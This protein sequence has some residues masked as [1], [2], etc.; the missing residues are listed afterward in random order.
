MRSA[1]SEE[2]HGGGKEALMA[3]TVKG[4]PHTVKGGFSLGFRGYLGYILL[5]L[6]ILAPSSRAEDVG[7]VPEYNVYNP[8]LELN[9]GDFMGFCDEEKLQALDLYSIGECAGNFLDPRIPNPLGVLDPIRDDRFRARIDGLMFI[10]L[11]LSKMTFNF[12]PGKLLSFPLNLLL[13]VFASTLELLFNCVKYVIIFAFSFM[14]TYLI[15]FML[16]FQVFLHGIDQGDFFQRINNAHT[17]VLF[18]VFT[19]IVVLVMG[20]GWIT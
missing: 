10:S 2:A 9:V 7:D 4:I 18:M 16:V 13:F 15:Y 11:D 19:T 3:S 14:K 5:Y 17:V 20:G 8:S 12:D 1:N 6:L